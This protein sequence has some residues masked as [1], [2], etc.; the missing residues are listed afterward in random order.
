MKNP[1]LEDEALGTLRQPDINKI[2]CKD[3]VWRKEDR[4]DGQ[5]KGATLAVCEVFTTKPKEI[6]LRNEKCP[7][8]VDD[9][10]D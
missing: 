2:A 5:I 9:K 10:D 6:L 3:C 1:R 7:Y 8:Y 4:L